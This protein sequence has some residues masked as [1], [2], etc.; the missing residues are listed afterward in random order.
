MKPIYIE[1]VSISI[2]DNKLFK[3]KLCKKLAYLNIKLYLYT[4]NKW[5][6]FHKVNFQKGNFKKGRSTPV[7]QRW[8]PPYVFFKKKRFI[9]NFKNNC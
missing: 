4:I 1:F 5:V 2:L 9:K 3:K 6:M 7:L 8:S